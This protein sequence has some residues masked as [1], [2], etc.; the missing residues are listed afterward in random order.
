M[1]LGLVENTAL[2]IAFTALERLQNKPGRT[3][4]R[5]PAADVAR[6]GACSPEHEGT[7][8]AAVFARGAR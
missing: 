8:L 4:A 2:S 5:S 7:A 1:V 3:F 6:T